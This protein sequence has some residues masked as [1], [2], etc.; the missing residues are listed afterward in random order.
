MPLLV[1]TR[2]L[3]VAVLW[4]SALFEKSSVDLELMPNEPSGG[5][6]ATSTDSFVLT[7]PTGVL[8]TCF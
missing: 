2:R 7:T 4:Y 1:F 5:V 3:V 8:T 6:V